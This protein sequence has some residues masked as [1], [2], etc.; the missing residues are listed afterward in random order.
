MNRPPAIV[1]FRERYRF[2]SNF[3]ICDF[4]WDGD[5]WVSAEHAY[6]AAKAPNSRDRRRIRRACSPGAAKRMGREIEI[7]RDWEDV[8]RSIMAEIVTAKFQQN[9][10]LAEKLIATHPATLIEGNTWHDNEWGSCSC[11]RCRNIPGKNLLGEIVMTVRAM[12]MADAEDIEHYR[13]IGI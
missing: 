7:R 10:D 8:K 3:W 12:L 4:K 1:E 9:P 2:L 13:D 11:P 5:L 6:Q